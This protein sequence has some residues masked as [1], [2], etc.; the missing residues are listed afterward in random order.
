MYVL[1]LA[2]GKPSAIV[3]WN[4]NYGNDPDRCILFHCSNFPLDILDKPV[5]THHVI[6]AETVGR[7]KTFGAVEGKVKSGPLAYL[8]LSTDDCSGSIIG[9]TGEGIM[10]ED[11]LKTF[12]GVGVAHIP[13]LQAL[14]QKICMDGFEHH[15][16]INLSHTSRAIEEALC[17]YMKWNIYL[18]R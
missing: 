6:L 3:D 15:V 5:M 13:N 10:T 9:Y 4:N 17:R 11:P 12:G 8:R 1:Q 18:H 16:A 7:D 2:S 14:L